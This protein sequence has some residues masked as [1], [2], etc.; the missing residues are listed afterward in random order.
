MPSVDVDVSTPR[1]SDINHLTHFTSTHFRP[2]PTMSPS[3][4][5]YTGAHRRRGGTGDRVERPD[6]G[7]TC[8]AAQKMVCLPNPDVRVSHTSRVRGPSGGGSAADG[9]ELR[10]KTHRTGHVEC[11]IKN[12]IRGTR[13]VPAEIEK[14]PTAPREDSVLLA[15]VRD[16][17]E[18]HDKGRYPGQTAS[19]AS[20][21][22]E[23]R[24]PARSRQNPS[25]RAPGEKIDCRFRHPSRVL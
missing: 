14:T 6:A 15:A 20:V 8:G 10:G 25:S 21:P 22:C 4:F 9:P 24:Q 5:G 13:R 11:H 1:S 16:K 2:V 23:N 3:C 7:A 18:P 19:R 17:G 12:S